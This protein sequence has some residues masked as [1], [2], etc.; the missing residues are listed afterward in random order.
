MEWSGGE[1]G[2]PSPPD[3]AFCSPWSAND[4]MVEVSRGV[5][6]QA[7]PGFNYT[8]HNCNTRRSRKLGR[9]CGRHTLIGP[10]DGQYG[11]KRS[12]CKSYACGLCGPRKIRQVRKGIVQR[13]LEHR[14]QR[15]LTLTLDPK[16]LPPGLEVLG[17]IQYLYGVWR[18]MRV[19]L[20]RKLGKSLVFI[21]VVELQQNGNPHLHM[22]V[23]S[24]LP[25]E[26]IS[27]AWQALGGGSFTRIEY[28]DVHRVAAY[29]SK[30]VTDGSSLQ[31]LPAG[32][33]RFS[34]SRGLALFDRSSGKSGWILV[35]QP[36][37]FWR[38]RSAG[39]VIEHYETEQD[40]ARSLVSFVALQVD[41]AIVARLCISEGPRLWLELRRRKSP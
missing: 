30:Y 18:K 36:I 4:G 26:W 3:A 6:L 39:I 21:A 10:A 25:K 31:D 38:E 11:H 12:R 41:S 33:R 37:E 40:G 2:T 22:L 1:G 13:A 24:Y 35:R 27:A 23:G 5:G 7:P 17:K 19:Y 15:F 16:K 20:R 32:T 8:E 34:T 29:I 9:H 14:L 28:A